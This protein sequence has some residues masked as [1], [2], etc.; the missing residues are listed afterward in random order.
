M[1]K[2]HTSGIRETL[3][4]ILVT[5]LALVT[6]RAFFFQ[7]FTIP[8]GS[9]KDT[10]LIDDRLIVSRISYGLATPLDGRVLLSFS[11]PRRGDV[12]VFKYPYDQ[13]LD[14]SRPEMR[15]M[16]FVKRVVGIPGD[17][18]EIRAKKVFV[19][20]LPEESGHNRH[21]SPEVIPPQDATMVP[22][23]PATYFNHCDESSPA[24]L[25]KRDWMPKTLVPPG[26]YF[27]LGDNRD[28][29]YDSRFWGFVGRERIH[30][31]ALL[32]YWSWGESGIRW[33]RIGRGF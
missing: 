20:G 31:K 30:G 16:D 6:V 24:C 18:V 11:N 8:T 7:A 19:N 4:L 23:A 21:S 15:D 10:L 25:A 17:V 32:V 9:M 13:R 22:Q 5:L 33:S 29:S 1:E 27:V 12:I 26:Q 28:E 14:T 3:T 2:R